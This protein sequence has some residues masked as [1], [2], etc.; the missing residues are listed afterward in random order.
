MRGGG[1]VRVGG[2]GGN[3]GLAHATGQCQN[4]KSIHHKILSKL[5]R[6]PTII[7]QRHFSLCRKYQLKHGPNLICPVLRNPHAY[8]CQQELY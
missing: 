5:L 4:Y 1:E 2:G 8:Q 7:K 3:T 6:L